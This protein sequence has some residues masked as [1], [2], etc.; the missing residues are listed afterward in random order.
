MSLLVLTLMRDKLSPLLLVKCGHKIIGDVAG[1]SGQGI[2]P[3]FIR[4]GPLHRGI[5]KG[6]KLRLRDNDFATSRGFEQRAH[7][8]HQ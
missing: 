8:G 2:W 4:R 3:H 1:Q 7:R 6:A 5:T